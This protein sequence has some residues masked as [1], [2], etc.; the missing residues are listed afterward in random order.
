MPPSWCVCAGLRAIDCAP[1]V[2]VLMH[3]CEFWRPTSTG[4]LINRVIP[5]SR[6]HVY[7]RDLPL[8]RAAIVQPGRTLWVLHP[9]GAPLPAAV[10]PE[11]VQI[12][13][14]DGTWRQAGDMMRAVNGWGQKVSLPMEGASRYWLRAQQDGGRFSTVEAL[15]FLLQALGLHATHEQLRLQFELHVYAGLCA[16]GKMADAARFL[17]DSPLRTA[18]PEVLAELPH[19]PPRDDTAAASYRPILPR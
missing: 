7:R 12:L 3:H 16:R 5:T 18:M 13:L 9:S 10:P 14:L 17:E 11:N 2:D 19:R 4:H 1:R 8:D 15:L 6:Q